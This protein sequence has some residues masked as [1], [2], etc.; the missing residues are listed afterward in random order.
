[1]R[2]PYVEAVTQNQRNQSLVPIYIVVCVRVCLENFE[3]SFEFVLFVSCLGSHRFISLWRVRMLATGDPGS[4]P[5][6]GRSPG[7]GNGNPPQYSCLENPMDRGL[8]QATVHGV[9]K[10]QTW[11]SDWAC[12]HALIEILQTL[13]KCCIVLW[14]LKLLETLLQRLQKYLC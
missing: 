7:E 1:M 10:C 2:T 9:T 4:I 13:E 3:H 14:G 11:L 5:E 12:M 6:L 8:W